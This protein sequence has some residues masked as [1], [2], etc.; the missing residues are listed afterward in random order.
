VLGNPRK[1]THNAVVRLP[2][3]STRSFVG[4]L[5]AAMTGALLLTATPGAPASAEGPAPAR[6][7]S[8]WIPYWMSSPAKPQGIL[9]ATANADLFTDV[10][11]FWYSALSAPDGNVRL[12]INP[13]F[14]GGQSSI[15]WAM[16]QLRAAGLVVLPAIADGSGKGRMAS[17]IADP[18]KR[19]AHVADIV[20]LVMSQGFDGIDL[21]YEVFAFSD[22]R[23]TWN[24][25]QPN[26]T[27]FVQEL[28][29]AL[30]AQGKLLSV[31]IPPPCS[32][33]GACGGQSGYWV[34]N[35]TGIAPF[36]DLIRLMAY[37]FSYHAIGPIAPINW[38]TSIV[39]YSA[40]VIDPAKVQ[41][42]VPTY[43]RA[44]TRKDSA[45]KF[46]LSGTCPTNS[47]TAAQKSAF[48][49]LTA[50]ST[51]TDAEI[52]AI[53]A[54]NGVAA[55]TWD[56]KSKESWFEY[57]KNV[58]WVDSGGATQ[59]CSAKRVMWF[60]GPEAVL[61]RT[62]LVGTYG[63]KAAAYWTV[64]GENQ[65]QWP[66]I[67]SYAQSL[68]P[69]EANVT[70]VAEPG[71]VFGQSYALTANVTF[72]N[73]PVVDAEATL[74]FRDTKK[75]AKWESVQVVRT[76]QDG[77]AAFSVPAQRT[78][79]FQVVTAGAGGVAASQSPPI[80][81]EVFSAL[82]VR[83]KTP[84]ISRGGTAKIVVVARPAVPGQRV[85]IEMQRKT[86]WKF[87]TATKVNSKGRVAASV[88]TPKK[89][90]LWQFRAVV[91]PGG[92]VQGATSEPVPIRVKK[93]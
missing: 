85:R 90:G 24:A 71:A 45:G 92:G 91:R 35:M 2:R 40:G 23:A 51:A 8:G 46:R 14:S 58:T 43:G 27:A 63:I 55:A 73:A 69:A 26:W 80:L 64:G 62:Q 1:M 72:N 29:A 37:D 41:I 4:S 19:T 75:K 59:T 61:A 88:T 54:A 65:S 32:T 52:P 39:A 89:P 78:G 48:R 57:D 44:W 66:L 25:T 79:N 83:A 70:I 77:S 18:A 38:V 6:V 53:M 76:G 50:M 30:K 3:L 11:P 56:E 60:V 49:S 17:V 13:N 12:A 9:S 5:A 47:G 81:V 10:S 31:T 74:Q 93:K 33:S 67:R 7:V 16:G 42:G 68:A 15:S 82:T 22:G 21:D 28:G 20:N 86:G 36:V 84:V 34:Y 87:I